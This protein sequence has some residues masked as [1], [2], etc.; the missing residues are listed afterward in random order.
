MFKL[1][2]VGGVARG[3]EFELTLGDNIIGRDSSATI[4]LDVNGV[5]KDT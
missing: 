5:S 3:K 4:V 2:V 1:V